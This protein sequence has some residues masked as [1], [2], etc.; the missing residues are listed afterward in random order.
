MIFHCPEGPV[1]GEGGGCLRAGGV[2][3]KR[4]P[5]RD[6]TPVRVLCT[7]IPSLREQGAVMGPGEFPAALVLGAMRNLRTSVLSTPR[8]PLGHT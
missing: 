4:V 3:R 5:V 8:L 2:S 6:R 1:V 7:H